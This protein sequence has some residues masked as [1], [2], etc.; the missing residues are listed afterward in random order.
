MRREK[1][2]P[3]DLQ[4][5]SG[6]TARTLR[7]E[8]A[9]GRYTVLLSTPACATEQTEHSWLGSFDLSEWTWIAWTTPTK[10][11]S[12]MHNKDTAAMHVALR[13]L[14]SVEIKTDA[15]LWLQVR[16]TTIWPYDALYSS[17]VAIRKI[18]ARRVPAG[19]WSGSG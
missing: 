3:A 19:A 15:P 18:T 2:K 10:A 5:T 6:E 8:S 4:T 14:C 12:R 16:Y 17:E 9:T 1:T 11:T 13:D 7:T